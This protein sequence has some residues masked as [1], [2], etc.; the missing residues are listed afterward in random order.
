MVGCLELGS[1]RKPQGLF[2]RQLG[3]G[4][5]TAHATRDVLGA[6]VWLGRARFL[7]AQSLLHPSHLLYRTREKE[8]VVFFW[9]GF[10]LTPSEGLPVTV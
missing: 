9:A 1:A 4:A 7:P 3:H 2:G 6:R 5:G 10:S 8:E